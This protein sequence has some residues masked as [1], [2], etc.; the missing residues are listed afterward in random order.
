MANI[1]I[2]Q[3]AHEI[4]SA[5]REYTEDVAVAI[6]KKVDQVANKVLKEAQALAPK[7]TG[8]Y[9][10]T[11]VK[12]KEG[13]YGEHRRII[14]NKKHYRRVHLLEFG[15]AKV[16]GGRVPAYPHLRPA[17][18]KHAANLPDEIKEIIRNGG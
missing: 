8:E 18:E 1:P 14:W 7:R 11:F 6:D 2:D 15:H 13:G 17:Y 12:T 5:V 16:N 4:T 9:A 3:L 10:K